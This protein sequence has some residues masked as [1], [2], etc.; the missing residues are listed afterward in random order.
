MNSTS[1][2]TY[3]P[4]IDGLRAVAVLVVVLFH[5]K[6]GFTGGFIGVDVFFVISGFLITSLIMRELEQQQFS[7]RAFWE[8]RVRR[9]VPAVACTVVACLVIGWFVLLPKDYDQLAGSAIAQ[10]TLVANIYFWRSIGYFDVVATDRPLLHTWSLAVEEQFYL[11][12]PIILYGA[13]RLGLLRRN[14]RSVLG[15]GVVCLAGLC[16]A[17]C[18]VER[19]QEAAFYLLPTRTWELLCGAT[20][21]LLPERAVIASPVLRELLSWIGFLAIIFPACQY[22]ENTNFPGIAAVPP[23]IGTALLIWANKPRSQAPS[24]PTYL[25]R[26]L[27]RPALVFIGL[28]SYSLYLWHWP[29]IVFSSYWAVH[30][31]SVFTRVSLILLSFLLAVLSWKYV[32]LPFRHRGPG[33]SRTT[34]FAFTG[35]SAVVILSVALFIHLGQGLPSR[36]PDN[37]LSISTP[38]L[39]SENANLERRAFEHR[40]VPLMQFSRPDSNGRR[41]AIMIWGDSHAE[42]ALPAFQSIIDDT[43]TSGIA[44]IR[45]DCPPV[46]GGG[47]NKSAALNHA[48]ANVA[49]AVVDLVRTEEIKDTFL[50]AYWEHYQS[51]DKERLKD[52]VRNTVKSLLDA[53][54][55]TWIVL[56]APSHDVSVPRALAKSELFA[57]DDNTWRRTPKEH[58]RRN[59]AL[60]E[61]VN[62]PIRA[63]FIDPSVLL[64]EPSRD[65]YRVHNLGTPLYID[66]DHLS[67][68]GAMTAILPLLREHLV[69]ISKAE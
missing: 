26:V 5:A 16:V 27:S 4:D 12:W 54:T 6:L 56:D 30:P 44:A 14:Y 67:S 37:V 7:F 3:R 60:Y 36:I 29:V 38:E 66:R 45:Y 62:E 59:S 8:R 32:E 46:V 57:I 20:V 19:H 48:A 31:F 17:Q 43:H 65:Y 23:C 53:G 41:P 68:E 63:V 13:Y 39:S 24:Q 22:T 58:Q 25:F 55:Q 34:V 50:V 64:L 52:A 40:G 33:F 2:A 21:A 49:E 10:V 9:I 18:G 15:V 69:G 28:I 11:G 1:Y 35:V 61:L 42:S 47:F 51:M